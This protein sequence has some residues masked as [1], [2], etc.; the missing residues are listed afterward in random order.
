VPL[1]DPCD[2]DAACRLGF[3]CLRAPQREV[4]AG[5]YCSKLACTQHAECGEDG[6]CGIAF[7]EAMCLS[8]CATATDCRQGYLCAPFGANQ[9]CIPRCADEADCKDTDFPFCDTT[10]GL[11][12]QSQT[13]GSGTGWTG[14]TPTPDPSSAPPGGGCAAGSGSLVAALAALVAIVRLRGRRG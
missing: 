14:Q 1:G 5:G 10:T 9:A 6:L 11:C 4:F 8:R 2:V 3:S 7:G 12:S 13:P